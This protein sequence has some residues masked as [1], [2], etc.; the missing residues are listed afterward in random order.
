M[1]GGAGRGRRVAVVTGGDGAIGGA[2][3]ARL[4]HDHSVVMVDRVGDLGVDPGDPAGA[5]HAAQVVLDRYGRCDVFV[6]AEAMAA[7]GPFDELQLEMWRQV[8]TVNVGSALLLAQ[9]IAPG[10]QTR[11]FGPVIFIMSGTYHRR[12]PGAHVL[13]YIASQRRLV[14]GVP[15]LAVG[16]GANGIAVTAVAAGPTR[17]LAT[18]NVPPDEFAEAVAHR[19]VPRPLTP[20][21]TAAV[22]A[23]LAVDD[24]AA[25]TG[26]TL[27]V[28]R[29]L[30]LR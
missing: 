18:V 2:I 30:V 12:P 10:M 13:A 17:T 28:D 14:G 1:S 25:L 11:G 21:D 8:Q 26:Q 29:G 24:A 9:A 19:P 3:A 6:H 4:E 7:F 27:T 15:A 23:M 5:R 16:R 22:V 20:D